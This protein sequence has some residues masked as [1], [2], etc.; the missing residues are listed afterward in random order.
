VA[1]T[2]IGQ[3]HGGGVRPSSGNSETVALIRVAPKT[4]LARGSGIQR[5]NTPC[6]IP[7]AE[8]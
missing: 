5:R 4:A 3:R 6:H 2:S 8:P 1:V 7:K